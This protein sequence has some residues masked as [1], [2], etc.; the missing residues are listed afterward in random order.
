MIWDLYDQAN[1]STGDAL[2]GEKFLLQPNSEAPIPKME[3]LELT[4]IPVSES[5]KKDIQT[6]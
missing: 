6:Q 1:G 3:P 2:T 5:F 4:Q